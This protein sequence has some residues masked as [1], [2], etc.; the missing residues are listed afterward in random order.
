[1]NT[2]SKEFREIFRSRRAPIDLDEY[3]HAPG[4]ADSMWH[5]KPHRLLYD[6]LCEIHH[7]RM[8]LER[9]KAEEVSDESA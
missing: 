4:D 6:C 5:N 7:L 9:L 3:W 2:P 8:E 1:M